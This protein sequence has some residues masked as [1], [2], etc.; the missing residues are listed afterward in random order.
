MLEQVGIE[1]RVQLN[2]LDAV[3]RDVDVK[4]RKVFVVF[5]G[6]VNEPIVPRHNPKRTRSSAYS[7]VR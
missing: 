6:A 3:R 2:T 1:P 4:L 5:V 7:R